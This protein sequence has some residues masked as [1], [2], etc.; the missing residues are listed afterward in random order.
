MRFRERILKENLVTKEDLDQIER[1]VED[2]VNAAIEFAEAS[3]EPGEK[4]MY[5]DVLVT[6]A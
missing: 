2:E 3:A 6:E 1:E 5:E 4:E